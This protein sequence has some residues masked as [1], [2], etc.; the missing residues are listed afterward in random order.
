M[1]D[2]KPGQARHDTMP[3]ARHDN[4][5]TMRIY[6]YAQGT[7]AA[8]WIELL[9]AALPGAEVAEWAPGA[10]PADYVV[11]WAP[12]QQLF[13]EQPQLKAIFNTGAGVDA[14][15]KLRLPPQVPVVRL[16]DAGMSVQM[17]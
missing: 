17:A 2:W 7:K 14:L 1:R 5:D 3:V 16:D 6:Y 15:L 9:R 8:P 11:V 13:D 4:P 12:P 10:P